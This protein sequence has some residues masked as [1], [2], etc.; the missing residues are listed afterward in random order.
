MK[1]IEYLFITKQSFFPV[2]NL[3]FILTQIRGAPNT[4]SSQ[5]GPCTSPQPWAHWQGW[6]GASQLGGHGLSVGRARDLGQ[7]CHSSFLQEQ[8]LS[9]SSR[10][11]ITLAESRCGPAAGRSDWGV[12]W[13][14]SACA[15]RPSRPGC[16]VGQHQLPLLLQHI[17]SGLKPP[18]FF[19]YCTVHSCCR[20][21]GFPESP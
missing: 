6:R 3:Q 18:H 5:Q 17:H 2:L 21:R 4:L 14:Q 19:F 13:G 16:A 11:E 1:L 15:P 9:C 10:K 12:C 7:V 8:K 20:V